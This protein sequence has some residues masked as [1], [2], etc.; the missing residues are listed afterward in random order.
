MNDKEILALLKD[1]EWEGCDDSNASCP[2]E[3][4][5][6][7]CPSC[8][9]EKPHEGTYFDNT[10]KGHKNWCQLDKAI[11]ELEAQLNQ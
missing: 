2:E 9:G 1:V 11:K 3:V 8:Q 4:I 5:R 7:V 6:P 10:G